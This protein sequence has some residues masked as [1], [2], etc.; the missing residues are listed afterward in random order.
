MPINQAHLEFILN[1][2]RVSIWWWTYN[3]ILQESRQ[4]ANKF[5][6]YRRGRGEEAVAALASEG[7]KAMFHQL[8][9]NELDS[10]TTAA[11]YFKDK[12]GGVDVLVN[13]AGIAFKGRLTMVLYTGAMHTTM[14]T[15]VNIAAIIFSDLNIAR[16]INI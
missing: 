3:T 8:D 16:I 9:I 6:L 15:C 14:L 10:I 7:L 5:K 11:A 13:N 2:L 12:Y 4:L 1:P